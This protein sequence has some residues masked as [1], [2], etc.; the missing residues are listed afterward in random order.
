MG[1]IQL[2]LAENPIS[3]FLMLTFIISLL[4]FILMVNIPGSQTPESFRGRPIWL[5]AIWSPNIAA[6][7]IWIIK[8]EL[9]SNIRLAFHFPT[10]SW[11]VLLALIPL[12][13]TITLLLIEVMNGKAIEWSNFKVGYLLPLLLLNLLMG[14][15]GE[16]LGWRGFLYPEIKVKYGWMASAMIVGLIWSLWH[17]PLWLLDSPQ[18]K[19]PFWAFSINVM[20]LSILMSIIYN[21]SQGS[22]II[23]ILLHLTF[24]VSLGV[25]D[26]LGS[27][28]SGEFIIKSLYIYAPMVLILV[29]IHE[30]TSIDKC[31]LKEP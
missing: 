4:S 6:I 26:I 16:E 31:I 21:H 28:Q 3:G 22:I 23:V 18:S 17:A 20:L 19:I 1:K 5:I 30:L 12:I 8:K 24:N 27:H 15:L 14:P 7:L 11:W 29:G 10:F 9:A 25:I 2:F 13:V